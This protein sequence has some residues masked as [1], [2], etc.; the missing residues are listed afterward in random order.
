MP[1]VVIILSVAIVYAL[2]RAFHDRYIR[3]GKW[4]TWA[5]IEGLFISLTVSYLTGGEWYVIGLGALL[6]GFTFWIVFD[7]IIG[8][9][10]GKHP[11]YLGNTGFDKKI[12]AMFQYTEKW[13][14]TWYLLV[15]LVFWWFAFY[16]YKTP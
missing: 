14:G 13:K 12:R 7:M 6:F 1:D 3:Q 15:K 10:F 9:Y 11:L 16:L 8:I 5:F 4:K 2:I